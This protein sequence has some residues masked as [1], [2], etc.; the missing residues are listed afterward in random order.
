MFHG[1]KLS[2]IT[3]KPNFLGL[4]SLSASLPLLTVSDRAEE[5]VRRW[6]QG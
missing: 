2:K 4:V 5:K 1:L 6:T 3:D